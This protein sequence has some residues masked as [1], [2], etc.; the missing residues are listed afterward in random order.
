[1]SFE[2]FVPQNKRNG[3]LFSL[4]TSKISASLSRLSTS[5]HTLS[6]CC[7]ILTTLPK[8]FILSV[9][10]FSISDFCPPLRE[11]KMKAPALHFFFHRSPRSGL[12]PKGLKG[13]QRGKPPAN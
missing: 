12:E 3:V 4:D 8:S 6:L 11:E 1:V 13:G 10:I 9:G 2:N 7:L 5:A